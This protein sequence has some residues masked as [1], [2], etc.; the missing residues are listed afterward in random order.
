M[1]TGLFGRIAP[2]R[3][4]RQTDLLCGLGLSAQLG[5]AE[6]LPLPRADLR[7]Q[8]GNHVARKESCQF[9]VAGQRRNLFD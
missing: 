3:D 8:R 6:V 2:S 7:A 1:Q 9:R 4:Y 5:P